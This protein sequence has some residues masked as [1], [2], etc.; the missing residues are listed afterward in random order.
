MMLFMRQKH[1][2]I[3]QV[4]ELIRRDQLIRE[5]VERARRIWRLHLLHGIMMP[6]GERVLVSEQDLH[7]VLLHERILR[8]P[9][10]IERL[11]RS[12]FELR[13]TGTERRRVGLSTWTEEDRAIFGYVILDP[14]NHLRTAIIADA[15]KLRKLARQGSQL[16]RRSE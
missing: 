5:A 11:I 15:R 12:V 13:S 9:E 10:R 8:K 6:N 1:E 4:E 16:W 7:H 2:P 3:Q 14:D